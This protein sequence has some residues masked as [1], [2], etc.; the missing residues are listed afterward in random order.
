MAC[1]LKNAGTYVRLLLVLQT[2]FFT[3]FMT[4]QN[5]PKPTLED[6]IPGGATY[7]YPENI[8]VCN[9]RVTFV[10]YRILKT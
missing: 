8:Y 10:F 4:A 6:L 1:L 7:R 5:N 9:G 3:S 2:L